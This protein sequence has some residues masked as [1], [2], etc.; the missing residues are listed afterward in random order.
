MASFLSFSFG[1]KIL[2]CPRYISA[3]KRHEIVFETKKALKFLT[4]SIGIGVDK[5]ET[6]V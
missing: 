2:D 4:E 6:P 3:I 1:P 5:R